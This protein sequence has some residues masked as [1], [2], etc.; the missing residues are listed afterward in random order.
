MRSLIAQHRC[1]FPIGVLLSVL[2]GVLP[3]GC[4]IYD[5]SLLL[6]SPAQDSGADSAAA[7]SSFFDSSVADSSVVDSAIGDSALSDVSSDPLPVCSSTQLDCDSD[8]AN[9]C[10]TIPPPTR[11]TAEPVDTTA[12]VATVSR[13]GA[14]PS[15]WLPV[16]RTPLASPSARLMSIGPIRTHQDL[17]RLLPSQVDR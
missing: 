10:E 15:C 7:D 5:D 16:R 9:G 2:S 4:S 8:P 3:L 6:V 17:W 13:E 14:Y 1:A 11:S 12:S